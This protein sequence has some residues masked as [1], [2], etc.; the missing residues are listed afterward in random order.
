[1]NCTHTEACR[2]LIVFLIDQSRLGDKSRL[3][4]QQWLAVKCGRKEANE[5]MLHCIVYFF[6]LECFGHVIT[7]FMRNWRFFHTAC[8]T[9]NASKEMLREQTCH[10]CLGLLCPARNQCQSSV[11]T[12]LLFA[13]LAWLQ[14]DHFSLWNASVT[15]RQTECVKQA[16][17]NILSLLHKLAAK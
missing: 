9:H 2:M 8:G 12:C 16:M 17:N 1:M 6:S 3:L 15:S 13:N 4:V 14:H 10:L 7:A 5:A 11:S